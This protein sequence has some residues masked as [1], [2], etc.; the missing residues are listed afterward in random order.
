[1]TIRKPKTISEQSKEK[2]RKK[3]VGLSVLT[4]AIALGIT[5]YIIIQ[6]CGRCVKKSQERK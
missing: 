3:Q 6:A 2:P 1:M 4:G 5:T